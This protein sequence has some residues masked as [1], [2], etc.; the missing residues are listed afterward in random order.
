[1][2]WRLFFSTFALIFLAELGDKTQLAS[3]AA[4]AGTKS[5]WSVFA[6]AASALVLSTLV[7]VLAGTF[8]QRV[9]PQHCIQG[10]A[11][12]LFLVF[13]II[14]FITAL[15]SYRE[16]Q[17]TKEVKV[18]REVPQGILATAAFKAAQG[19]EKGA[20]EDYLKMSKKTD[21]A[22]LRDLL[23]H[24]AEEEQGHLARIH[25]LTGKHEPE[26]FI[27]A[28]PSVPST[29]PEIRGRDSNSAILESAIKHEKITAGFYR[30]LAQSSVVAELRHAFALLASEEESHVAHLE[31]FRDTGSTDLGTEHT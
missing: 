31:E 7:A 14:L 6:G 13:G 2:E 12:V 23:I 24:L 15:Q 29:S 30:K 3:M 17:A 22:P 9:I 21:S 19:F 8:L 28:V 27:P 4:S 20:A 1:M 26:T 11:A 5:P 25:Q 16:A 18:T 10:V